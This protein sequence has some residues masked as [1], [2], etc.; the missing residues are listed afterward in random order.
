MKPS[1]DL[2]VIGAGPG[3]YPA[4]IRAGQLKLKTAIIEQ[5]SLGGVCLNV[6]CIPTKALLRNAELAAIVSRR[7]KEFGLAFDNLTLDYGAAFRRSRQVSERL[8]KGVNLLLEKSG[9]EIYRGRAIL[10]SPRRVRVETEAGE[11]LFLETEKIIIASGARPRSL[12]GLQTDKEKIITYTEA[13]LSPTLPKRAVII[14]GGP[15]GVE[16]ATIWRS[17]GVE[18][19]I[20]EILDRILSGEDPEVSTVIARSLKR[21]GVT[22]HTS[23]QVKRAERTTSGVQLTL[24]TPKGERELAADRLLVAAGFQPNTE[25]MGLDDLGIARTGKGGFIEV[26]DRMETSVPGVFAA[27]D[28]TGKLM[29]AH[30]AT[31]M[32]LAAA[33]SAAGKTP[34]PLDYRMIPRGVYSRPQVASF[35]LTEKD[36]ITAGFETAIGRFPFLANG[37]A[38]G[39]GERE[40]FVKIIAEAKTGKILG[41]SLAGP[42][43]TELLGELTLAQRSGLTLEDIAA[44]IHGHPTL[45]E[46]IAEAAAAGAGHAIHI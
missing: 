45:S 16:F 23:S 44:N 46:A 1:Y 19:K 28:V 12:P 31:A 41:A 8:V 26:D 14:G 35:G 13:I 40:G 27:G 43:V 20:V 21:E 36:A 3:G 18:V 15:V 42:E 6:G 22:V 4:A 24:A 2:I 32:G 30:A 9:A 33:E 17:Y 11:P 5:E 29:L 37:K 34:Q 38:R 39:M 7:A 10:E 25:G